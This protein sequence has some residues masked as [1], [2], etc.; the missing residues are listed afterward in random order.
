MLLYREQH[1][2]LK[3]LNNSCKY[4]TLHMIIRLIC[5]ALFTCIIGMFVFTLIFF[6]FDVY[7][8]QLPIINHTAWWL[9]SSNNKSTNTNFTRFDSDVLRITPINYDDDY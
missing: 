6:T 9:S 3:D 8:F 2:S 1:S 4:W 7:W 5:I